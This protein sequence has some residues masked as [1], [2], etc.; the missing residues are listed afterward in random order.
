MRIAYAGDRAIAVD[1]LKFILG[2]GVRPLALLLS[3]S[4][5]ATH[6]DELLEL[7]PF[8]DRD[9]IFRGTSFRKDQNVEKL[10][11]LELDYI[12]SIHFPYIYPEAVLDVAKHGVLNL[13]P[14]YLPYNR[15]WHTPTWAILEG[16]PYGGTLHFMEEALDSGD[17]VHQK[18]LE[19]LPGDTADSLYQRVLELEVEVFTEAWEGLSDFSY[20]RT[21]QDE[22]LATAHTKKDIEQIR[23]IE[24]DQ[25]ITPRSLIDKLRALTTN[26]VS[27]AAWFE[28]KGRRYMVQ[29]NITPDEEPGSD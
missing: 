21:S 14:A 9:M 26:R 1:V 27:E 29:V 13:H 15:G 8:L 19:A 7:C 3:S 20:S 18:K 12:I 11:K 28:E 24:M 17:I 23:R 4:K 22:H 25:E 6:A 10:S 2:Q 16:T 5:R